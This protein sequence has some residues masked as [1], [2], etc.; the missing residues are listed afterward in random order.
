MITYQVEKWK[1][2][3]SG[4]KDLQK[5]QWKELALDQETIPLNINYEHYAQLET[6]GML[7]ATTVRDG[8]KLVGY[9]LNVVSF[10]PHYRET[11]FGFCDAY[12]VLA[13][14]RKG[15][16]GLNLFLKM[17][18]FMKEIGVIELISI[19][20]KHLDVSA[21]FKALKWRETGITYTKVI[22]S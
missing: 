15:L 5:A 9:Y 7:H 4:I 13:N 10:H 14:Y 19:T 17:E 18:Q 8:E 22:Q 6:Q 11:P 16:I 2:I 21:L 3:E 12:Y 1:D 20:K